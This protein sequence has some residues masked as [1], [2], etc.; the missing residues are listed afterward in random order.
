MEIKVK[1]IEP[2]CD[3]SQGLAGLTGGRVDGGK[4]V[5]ASQLEFE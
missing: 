2:E 3:S 5:Q 4:R 1:L